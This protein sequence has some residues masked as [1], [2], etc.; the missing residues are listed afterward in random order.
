MWALPIIAYIPIADFILLRG[1]RLELV[2]RMARNEENFLPPVHSPMHYIKFMKNGIILWMMTF[3]YLG[4]PFVII[5]ST[6]TGY[7]GGLFEIVKW[8]YYSLFSTTPVAPLSEI[9]TENSKNALFRL[10]IEGVWLIL[11][12]PLYRAAM[13]RFAFTHS[14]FSFFNVISNIQFL[15]KQRNLFLKT[16]VFSLVFNVLSLAATFLLTIT[17]IGI[18]FIPLIVLIVYYY[19]TGYEYGHLAQEVRTFKFTRRKKSKEM[20]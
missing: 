11:S 13:I 15:F 1:W 10:G 14:I 12:A 5:F 4:V 3:L 20:V 9:L 19:S 7:W 6:G 2:R 18:V 16:Y 17:G 8:V